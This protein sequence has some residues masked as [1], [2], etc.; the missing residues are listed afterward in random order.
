MSFIIEKLA[1][2]SEQEKKEILYRNTLDTEKVLNEVILPMAAAMHENPYQ[3]LCDYTLRFDKAVPEPFVLERS[4]LQKAFDNVHKENPQVLAAFEKAYRNIYDFHKK[5]IPQGFESEIAHNRLGYKFIPFD[6]AA[7]YVPGGKALYP[8]T[9]LMGITPAALAGVQ[10]ILLLSPPSQDG[11]VH[12]IV[13][14]VAYL[15]GARR[16]LQAGGAQAIF[17]AAYG[18]PQ[19]DIAPCDYIYGPG[20]IYVAVAKNYVFSHNLCGIDG[21]AGPSEVVIIADKSAHPQYL[22]HDLLA[23]AEHD[24]NALALLL[25]TD[26]EV[27]RATIREIEKAVDARPE[28]KD[29]T[30]AAMRRNGRFLLCQNLEEAV[31]FSNRFA[32]EHLE[33]QT[34]ENDW[35]LSRVRSAGS[36]FVG[37]FAP[38]A[39]GDY[40]S[41]TNHI[42]PTNRGARFGSGVSTQSF[43]RRVTYQIASKEGL[44]LAK[45]SIT[46]MSK[47]EGLFN[48]HGYSVLTRFE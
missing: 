41:G 13:Q 27:A 23:Q 20:N 36:V 24:E 18:V 11:E 3:K 37:D 25:I 9:V 7:L 32:P 38:V 1:A 15:A 45:E 47:E 30:L 46:L 42:L 44:E 10:D 17:A 8:S 40:F 34:Q 31:E 19:L 2:L 39:L 26:E 43:Y 21:F 14:A 5:Q 6:S 16:L 35:L 12:K 48:E 4:D 29:I 28:R 22:A 33:I